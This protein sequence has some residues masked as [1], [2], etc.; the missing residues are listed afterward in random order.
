M[1]PGPIKDPIWVS[2][3]A[4]LRNMVPELRR[5]TH[6]AVDTESN[7]LYVYQEQVCLIQFSTID[8]DYLVD[9]LALFDLSELGPIFED[10][11][12]EKIFHAA[13]YDILC[14]KRDFGF[15]FTNLFD[16]MLAARIL[17]RKELGLGNLLSAEFDLSLDK[18][19]QRANWG[20]RPLPAG[21]LSY[22]RMDTHYLTDLRDRLYN[23]LVEKDLLFLAEEDFRRMCDLRPAPLQPEPNTCWSL[24]SPRDITPRQAAILQSLVEFRDR[25]ARYANVPTFK[26]LSNQTL[27]EITQRAP[28]NMDELAGIIGLPLSLI[29]RFGSDI[30][31]AVERG[32]HAPPIH[33]PH[34]HRPPET[35]IRRMETLR[36]WRK[37]A[38]REM[39][40]ESDVILPREIMNSI[41][42]NNPR[43]PE[44]LADLM[45]PVPWRL[46]HF[47]EQIFQVISPRRKLS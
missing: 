36:T 4:E 9:P 42:E 1:N 16:T 7:G 46:E 2:R 12:I 45:Q 15:H 11:G 20:K 32:A 14:L 17:G 47:G 25:Q 26:I 31:L 44:E 29:D 5:C 10:S 40:V 33:A 38:G 23:Q 18:R 22:A 21:M 13:E 27:L 6:L 28:R 43:T 3:P 37:E 39:G 35:V 30:L 19:H 24:A 41:A 8:T 34:N